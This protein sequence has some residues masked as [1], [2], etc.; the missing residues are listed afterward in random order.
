MLNQP[1]SSPMMK[2]MF[3]FL[4]AAPGCPWPAPPLASAWTRNAPRPAAAPQH[5]AGQ[6]PSVLGQ[7]PLAPGMEAS[8]GWV[9]HSRPDAAA[10]PS[11]APAA[12]K[13]TARTFVLRN[14][15][16]PG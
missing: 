5:G 4:P 13:T 7:V 12:R 6:D 11:S 2:T 9:S 10:Y 14:I 15:G 1:T 3:G 8:A 16:P